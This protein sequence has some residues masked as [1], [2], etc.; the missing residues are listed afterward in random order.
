MKLKLTLL[1]AIGLA[2]ANAMACYTVYDRNDRISYQGE[3]PPVDMSRPLHETL[4][5]A[6]PGS[7][8]VFDQSVDCRAVNAG[9][10]AAAA[11]IRR[12]A[13]AYASIA[14][15]TRTMGAG[16]DTRAMG[17]G[18]ATNTMGAAPSTRV[19]GAAAAPSS[20]MPVA[21]AAPLLTDRRTANALQLPYTVMS[22]DIVMVPAEAAARVQRPGVNVL[23][24][25]TM[26]PVSAAG[27]NVRGRDTVIT[28][29][30]NPPM[31]VVES[32][33]T[34]ISAR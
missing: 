18:P 6:Y 28:E 26:S 21:N 23:P 7:Q 1:C 29:M 2:S 3:T 4:G 10:Q 33:N 8:L 31:T 30:Y 5:R 22:G 9:R 19:M 11:P 34:I 17:A 20:R 24:H 12:P 14:P 15:A 13:T 32:G 27:S 16:P 25:E